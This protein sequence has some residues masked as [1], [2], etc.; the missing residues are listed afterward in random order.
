MMPMVVLNTDCAFIKYFRI[1]IN[2]NYGNKRTF[3][4]RCVPQVSEMSFLN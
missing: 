3:P 2:V 4:R 1:I